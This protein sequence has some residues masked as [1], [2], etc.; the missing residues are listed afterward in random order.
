MF[1]DA[2]ITGHEVDGI[3]VLPRKAMLDD[4]RVLVVQLELVGVFTWLPTLRPTLYH[5]EVD[6]LRSERDRVVLRGGVEP[7]E[8]ICVSSLDAAV[9]G[10]AVR[11]ASVSSNA[12]EERR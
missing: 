8:W 4:D 1:V 3:V 10:M 5:R 6:V 12:G 7:G 11:V 9:D 2:R